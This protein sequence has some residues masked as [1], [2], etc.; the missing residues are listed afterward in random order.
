MWGGKKP[1]SIKK[2]KN[3]QQQNHEGD[4]TEPWCTKR[5]DI[6]EWDGKKQQRPVK[7]LKIGEKNKLTKSKTTTTKHN[8]MIGKI[9]DKNIKKCKQK[10]KQK[11]NMRENRRGLWISERKRAEKMGGRRW[12]KKQ[13]GAEN[14]PNW[15]KTFSTEKESVPDCWVD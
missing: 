6:R 11:Y 3:Q 8:K 15:E 10:C 5:F 1:S 4:K 12:S 13:Q 9:K 14:P 2:K 7:R